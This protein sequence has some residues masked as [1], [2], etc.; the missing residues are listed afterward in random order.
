MTLNYSLAEGRQGF[1]SSCQDMLKI[2]TLCCLSSKFIFSTVGT[3]MNIAMYAE[4][5]LK[6]STIA[7]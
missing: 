4:T 6:P 1:C 3:V 5:N 7:L 2:D